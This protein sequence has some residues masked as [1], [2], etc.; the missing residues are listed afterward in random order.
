M[1]D[2]FPHASHVVR[3]FTAT[4]CGSG[5]EKHVLIDVLINRV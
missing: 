5:L 3:A 1:Y 4:W 2:A